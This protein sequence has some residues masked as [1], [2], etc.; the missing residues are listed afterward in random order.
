[1]S[2]AEALRR[3]DGINATRSGNMFNGR[4]FQPEYDTYNFNDSGTGWQ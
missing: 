3:P 2:L 1:M 4:G